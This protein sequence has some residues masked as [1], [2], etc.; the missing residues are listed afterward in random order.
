RARFETGPVLGSVIAIALALA[1]LGLLRRHWRDAHLD[2]PNPARPLLESRRL[3]G[4]GLA[5]VAT[6][7]ALRSLRAN[8]FGRIS[9]YVPRFGGILEL[10]ALFYLFL[11]MLQ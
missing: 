2:Q 5:S 11:G 1:A 10:G 6:Y 3:L 7:A 8:G 4:V 9:Q